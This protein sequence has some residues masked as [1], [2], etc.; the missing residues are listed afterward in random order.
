MTP[1]ERVTARVNRLGD[2][3]QRGTQ[4]P[5]LTIAEFFDGN[6]VSGSIGCNLLGSPPPSVMRALCEKI[7]ARDEVKDVRVVVTQFDDPDWPFSD[8]IFVMTTAEPDEVLSWFPDELA[9]DEVLDRPLDDN[10]FE[11][12]EVPEGTKAILCWW[13]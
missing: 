12:Y 11:S 10:A 7:A 6:E 5:M 4:L 9:P 3:N 13:D 2:V 8:T 1:L